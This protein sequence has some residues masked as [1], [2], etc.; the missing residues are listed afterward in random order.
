MSR[1]FDSR[2]TSFDQ[3]GRL[4]QVEYAMEAIN[5]AG[6]AIGV[7]TNYGIIL[8]TEKQTVSALLEQSKHSEK[9]FALDK[10]LYCVVSGV[11]AD[12]NYLIDYARLSGQQYR[13]AFRDI[14]PIDQFIQNICD[15]KQRYTQIGGIRPFG[16]AFL[17]AGHD[18]DSGYQ[19]YSSDPSGNYVG[20]KAKAI[21]NNNEAANSYLKE[22]YK[23]D[24]SLY[25]GLDLA[26]QTLAKA[27][28]STLTPEKIEI[29]TIVKKSDGTVTGRTL[30]EAEL[31]KLIEKNQ[32]AK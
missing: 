24:L 17:Y 28:T 11:T 23:E 29:M 9:I 21:G 20:W 13:F 14:Q 27:L 4:K 8:A 3:E 7:L 26:V 6:S 18:H 30:E 10:H 31:A 22:K 1:R 2:T 5:K 25:D 19:L 12:A 16:A 15:L 32:P